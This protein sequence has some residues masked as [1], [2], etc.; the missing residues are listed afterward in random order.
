[1]PTGY[2]SATVWLVIVL[3]GVLT[4]AIRG[5]FIYLFGRIDDVPPAVESA[6]EYVPAAVFAAL[7]FPALL[8]PAGDLAVSVGNEKLVAGALAALAAW[9]TER[10]LATIL[11]GMGALWV[12]RFVV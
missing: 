3:A 11:V 4:F 7:V 8:A 9:Y 12:L 6:L 1:M 2:D 5:S 10:V